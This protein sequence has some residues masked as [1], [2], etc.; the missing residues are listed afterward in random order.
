MLKKQKSNTAYGVI[1][2]AVLIGV[3]LILG[4][5]W[6]GRSAR[7]DTDRAVRS[8][9]LLYLDELA[10]RREQVVGGNLQNKIRDMQVA[11]S[12]MD[13]N[14]LK[15]IETMRAYQLRMR[16]LYNAEKFAF[17]SSDGRIYTA[18]G[19]QE[20]IEDY[21][22][23]YQNLSGPEIS[24]YNIESPEKKVVIVSAVDIPFGD[25]SFV[26]SFMEIDMQEMLSGVSMDN[27]EEATFCNIYT[28]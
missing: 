12:L 11:V 22:F 3:F 1:L 28:N 18:T 15:D 27:N 2:A 4:T 24:I 21:S 10:G 26:A 14:D 23:D 8:V 20:N 6:M 19:I 13:E 16:Q 7:K 25:V 9:S 5:V 17:V